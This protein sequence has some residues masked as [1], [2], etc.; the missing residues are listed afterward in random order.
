[1]YLQWIDDGV[2][3]DWHDGMYSVLWHT[4]V[5]YVVQVMEGGGCMVDRVALIGNSDCL[6]C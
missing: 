1:V 4:R 6:M 2:H 3:M 5:T